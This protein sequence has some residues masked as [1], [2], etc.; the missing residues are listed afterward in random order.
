MRD[1]S[2]QEDSWSKSCL[3]EDPLILEKGV[4]A[5]LESSETAQSSKG[6]EA[7]WMSLDKTSGCVDQRVAVATLLAPVPA[8][9]G[10]DA[11]VLATGPSALE[12]PISTSR[13]R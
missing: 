9:H 3:E 13:L 4:S 11:V 6:V 1:S 12:V 5:T 8:L 2:V 10:F 7:S